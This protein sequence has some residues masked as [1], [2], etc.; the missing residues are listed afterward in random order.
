MYY[1]AVRTTT[2]VIFI[3]HGTSDLLFMSPLDMLSGEPALIN[4][5]ATR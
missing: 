1:T 2:Y 4:T 3:P 5:V